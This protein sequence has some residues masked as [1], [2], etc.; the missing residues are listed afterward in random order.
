[1]FI[2]II[3]P[4]SFGGYFFVLWVLMLRGCPEVSFNLSEVIFL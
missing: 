1:M 2:Q 4:S 3:C